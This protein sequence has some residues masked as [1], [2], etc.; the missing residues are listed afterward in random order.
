[1]DAEPTNMPITP[2]LHYSITPQEIPF[3]ADQNDPVLKEFD[4]GGM[5]RLNE[6]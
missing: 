2:S 3:F 6:T 4:T 1:M 5:V